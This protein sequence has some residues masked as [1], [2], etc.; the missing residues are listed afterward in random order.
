MANIDNQILTNFANT[1]NNPG[2]EDRSNKPKVSYVYAKAVSKMTSNNMV[3]VQIDG[4]EIT[5][6]VNSNVTVDEGDRVLIM[7]R[8]HN[9]TIV[10]NTTTPS[11]TVDFMK[12]GGGKTIIE[13]QVKDYVESALDDFKKSLFPIGSTYLTTIKVSPATFLGGTWE[14]VNEGYALMSVIDEES[15]GK[16]DSIDSN[17]KTVSGVPPHEHNIVSKYYDSTIINTADKD[18]DGNDLAHEHP[19]DMQVTS[20]EAS[21]YGLTQTGGFGDRVVVSMQS[22][23]RTT[24]SWRPSGRF[25]S[26]AHNIKAG[27]IARI[28]KASSTGDGDGTVNVTPKNFKVYMWYRVA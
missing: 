26:H 15:G 23:T 17:T 21:G 8:N 4:S 24:G 1:I 7:L 6:P 2:E 3:D 25:G 11:T 14:L 13:D 10:G 5:C 22:S 16:Y 28:L 9:A 20:V 27:D 19:L 12:S 18:I